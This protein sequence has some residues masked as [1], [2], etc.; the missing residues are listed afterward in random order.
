MEQIQNV[1]ISEVK[2]YENNPRNNTGAVDATA[3]SIKEFGWQQPIVVD[4]DMVIIAGHTRYRAAKLLNLQTVPV[5]VAKN[6]SD[7][8]V[9]AYRLADNKVGELADWDNKKLDEELSKVLDID[10]EDFGFELD[11]DDV[12]DEDEPVEGDIPVSDR[13]GIYHDYVVLKFDTEIDWLQAQTFFNLHKVKWDKK[14]KKP[15]VGTGR[16]LNGT[17]IIKYLLEQGVSLNDIDK[18]DSKNE[19]DNI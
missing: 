19:T 15:H 10:M 11:V 17:K 16:V 9:T 7:E 18:E 1:S 8:Q 12:L 2:P 14:S 5:V 6:L 4:K 13:I 3:K